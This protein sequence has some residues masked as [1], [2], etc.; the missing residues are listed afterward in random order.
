MAPTFLALTTPMI[1]GIILVAFTIGLLI[2]LMRNRERCPKD[3]QSMRLTTTR[4][5]HHMVFKCPR[6]GHQKKTQIPVGRR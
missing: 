4:S 5:S 3:G 1:V 2:F 6:C